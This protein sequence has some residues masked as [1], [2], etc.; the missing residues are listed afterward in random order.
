MAYFIVEKVFIECMCIWSISC[1]VIVFLT[2]VVCMCH[3]T[4]MW[5]ETRSFGENLQL[6]N[7]TTTNYMYWLMTAYIIMDMLETVFC[8]T[9]LTVV[10]DDDTFKEHPA[11]VCMHYYTWTMLNPLTHRLADDGVTH[12]VCVRYVGSKVYTLFV[13]SRLQYKRLTSKPTIKHLFGRRLIP[14][15]LEDVLAFT[16]DLKTYMLQSL[17]R[18]SLSSRYWGQRRR[19]AKY[20]SKNMW[21]T[22][23]LKMLAM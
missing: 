9:K 22:P 21:K 12:Y 11:C 17:A 3:C 4:L 16:C 10:K 15:L 2:I 23:H 8:R 20:L 18:K 13:R 19:N 14:V 7:L 5:W 6:S 1:N